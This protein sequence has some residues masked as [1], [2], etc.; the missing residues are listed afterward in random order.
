[1]TLVL[2]RSSR[3]PDSL[4]CNDS[5]HQRGYSTQPGLLFSGSSPRN[6][7]G[8]LAQG[9]VSSG[10]RLLLVVKPCLETI[11][12]FSGT[13]RNRF[14]AILGFFSTAKRKR[15]LGWRVRWVGSLLMTPVCA[16]A[17]TQRWKVT[18]RW[19][20]VRPAETKPPLT[21]E[22]ETSFCCSITG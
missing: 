5:S 9:C 8:N 2:T 3:T 10:N 13:K 16:G 7:R 18:L 22:S 15:A 12:A 21:A 14:A 11:R 6:M 19:P 1:M 4:S 17:G 20:S